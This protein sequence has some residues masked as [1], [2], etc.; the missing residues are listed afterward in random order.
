VDLSGVSER[1]AE[2]IFRVRDLGVALSDRRAVKLL[3][4]VAASAVLCG[5]GA[6][7]AADLWP[8]RYVWDR[9]EQIGPLGGLID[10][11]LEAHQ[12]EPAA[13]TLAAVRGRV[14]REELARQLDEAETELGRGTPGLAAV[15]RLR[16]HVAGLADRAAWV[17]DVSA[18]SHLKRRAAEILT[19]IGGE[20]R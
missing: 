12:G 15:A 10:G 16:E 14:D 1:Y 6:A 13:H 4:L 3:K 5:R 19:R 9:E 7:S 8:L 2:V 11:V 20:R 18:R 17:E